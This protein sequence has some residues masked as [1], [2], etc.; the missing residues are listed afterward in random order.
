MGETPEKQ[1]KTEISEE[2]K[3]F[4]ALQDSLMN[5]NAV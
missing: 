4:A 3:I 5:M 2:L 1:Q